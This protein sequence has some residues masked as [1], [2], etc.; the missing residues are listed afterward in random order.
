M[1]YYSLI[2]ILEIIVASNVQGQMLTNNSP[3]YTNENSPE[4]CVK[5]FYETL[6][7][8][9]P[10][11]E[12][13]KIFNQP[14][15]MA[16]SITNDTPDNLKK[17]GNAIVWTYFRKH[18]DSVG[19]RE[20]DPL[21]LASRIKRINYAYMFGITRDG[22]PFFD[23]EFSIMAFPD[24]S[25]LAKSGVIKAVSFP[26][27]KRSGG[28]DY[29]YDSIYLIEPIA[30]GVNGAFLDVENKYNRTNDLWKILKIK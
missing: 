28:D 29:A 23:H 18:K 26:M 16:R 12:C 8:D 17:N 10:V 15:E 24:G 25:A 9:K 13:P 3:E 2:L 27:R 11:A 20:A 19:F 1:N 7:S 30:I 14:W 21:K 5:V 6:Y 22:T 4:Y